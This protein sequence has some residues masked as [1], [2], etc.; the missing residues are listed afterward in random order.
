MSTSPQNLYELHGAP[1]AVAVVT[2]S[3]PPVNGLGLALRRQ[4]HA[5]VAA[6]QAD[7][8]VRAI[9]LIGSDKAF[10]GGA[11]IRELG[12]PAQLTEPLLRDVLAAVENSAKPVVAAISGVCLGGGLELALACQHRVALAAA[13]LG[14][15]E[16]KLGLIPGSGGTQRLPRLLPLAQAADLVLT[17][18]SVS[19]RSLA[20]TALLDQVVDGD[21]AALLAA[22]VALAQQLPAGGSPRTRDREVLG[23]DADLA[24]ARAVVAKQTLLDAPRAALQALEAVLGAD[25]DAGLQRERE[26]FLALQAGPQSRALRHVFQAERLAAKVADLPANTPTRAVR[27]VGVVGAGLMGTGIALNF[28]AIGL[29]VVLVEAKDEALQ[30]GLATLKKH[31]ED[32][33]KKGRFTAEQVAQRAALVTASTD[34][35]AFADCDLV[36]EAVFEDMAVKHSVFRQLDAVCKPG[37]ILASNTSTLDVGEIA[38]AT[39]RPADVVGLHFFSPANIMKLLEIVRVKTPVPTAPDVL[40]TAL[41]VARQI[42]KKPVV[43]GVCD[44][45]IGNRMLAGYF[46]QAN[47]AVLEGAEPTAVDR[48][49]EGFGLAMGPLRMNDLAGID[50][51][52]ASRKRRSAQQGRDMTLLADRIAESGRFGQKTG[53][54]W[55]R[56]EAGSRTPQP[57]PQTDAVIAAYRQAKGVTPRPVGAEEIVERCIYALVAEGARILQ[58]GIAQRASD[59][60]VVYTAGYGFPTWRGGPMCYAQEVGWAKVV[61]RMADFAAQAQAAGDPHAAAFWTPAPVLA[62]WAVDAA[63]APAAA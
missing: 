26:R 13:Q 63:A 21:R 4:I 31:D 24:D 7:A 30:R 58:E 37:A 23:S 53:S 3:N 1:A 59:I 6:A 38:A 43:S 25:F 41:E 10:S 45:F 9:V 34:Y 60:D 50:I 22:A 55:Y 44:G 20:G 29:P 27:R 42:G 40:A 19:A 32:G 12:T 11:D 16:V 2:L 8:Q 56:Y 18:R 33:L 17:G 54:G 52:W 28:I 46:A 39:A 57:E 48:A 49:I 36:I 14:L 35:A 62:Q 47:Q 51:G 61:A 15:P 5:A